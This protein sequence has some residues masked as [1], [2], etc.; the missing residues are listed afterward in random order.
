MGMTVHDMWR[1]GERVEEEFGTV[2]DWQE[3]LDS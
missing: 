1:D 2:I 3:L